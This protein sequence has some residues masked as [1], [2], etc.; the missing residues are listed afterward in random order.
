MWAVPSRAYW[1]GISVLLKNW[2]SSAGTG[3][4]P[5]LKKEWPHQRPTS[6]TISI[7]I[8]SS[9]PSHRTAPRVLGPDQTQDDSTGA[10]SVHKAV[11]AAD[12][13]HSSYE[14]FMSWVFCSLIGSI[15]TFAWILLHINVV[16]LLAL[17]FFSTS[18]P[19]RVK[20]SPRSLFLIVFSVFGPGD[21]QSVVLTTGGMQAPSHGAW[22]KS[23]SK[24]S[25]VVFN[26]GTIHLHLTTSRRQHYWVFSCKAFK[27]VIVPHCI[28][29]V[30]AI[31]PLFVQLLTC[32]MSGCFLCLY[33]C[34]LHV[35]SIQVLPDN[36]VTGC[37]TSLSEP[38][39]RPSMYTG[40]MTL[41]IVELQ[42]NFVF[43]PL[44]GVK[45]LLYITWLVVT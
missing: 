35:L 24:Y 6:E 23:L 27:R 1:T 44:E 36:A 37:S 9:Q 22:K 16:D 18:F 4:E 29:E 39:P 10:T 42:Y 25:S 8:T 34:S 30:L 28:I 20:I 40:R 12:D 43:F 14:C 11:A 13:C 15:C 41:F 38:F 32:M 7:W 3:V 19:R 17:M 26:F 45:R 33:F 2:L 5:N 31:V 21:S